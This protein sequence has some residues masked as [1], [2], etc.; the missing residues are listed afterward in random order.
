MKAKKSDVS[1]QPNADADAEGLN[2]KP[3]LSEDE[4][5]ER[6]AKFESKF[7]ASKKKPK[8]SGGGGPGAPY[9]A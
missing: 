2:E 4:L 1:D 5:K 9:E 7:E 3:I 8:S 6:L